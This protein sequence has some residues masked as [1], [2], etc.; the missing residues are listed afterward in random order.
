MKINSKLAKGIIVVGDDYEC[1]KAAKKPDVDTSTT[2]DAHK[3]EP[4][5]IRRL[6]IIENKLKNKG[7]K[8]EK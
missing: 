8:E 7:E 1:V 2:Q 4:T 5:G 3:A 6:S